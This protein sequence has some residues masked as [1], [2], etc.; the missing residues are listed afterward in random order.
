MLYNEAEHN[1]RKKC[2]GTWHGQGEL[3][4]EKVRDGFTGTK[5]TM[6]SRTGTQFAAPWTKSAN[7][8]KECGAFRE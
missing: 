4:V 2:N 1:T 3:L 8:A 6:P 7:E 5:M